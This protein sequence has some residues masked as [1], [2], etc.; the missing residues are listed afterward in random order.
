MQ[1]RRFTGA[2]SPAFVSLYHSQAATLW[3]ARVLGVKGSALHDV[4]QR[5]ARH[6]APATPAI[7]PTPGCA[8]KQGSPT[9][10]A[11]TTSLSSRIRSRVVEATEEIACTLE[12]LAALSRNEAH[13]LRDHRL[14]FGYVRMFPQITLC[15]EFDRLL[16]VRR[17]V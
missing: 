15:P 9:T 13:G 2:G 14:Q 8:R 7:P 6:H 4:P 5:C 10:G 3:R 11:M 16:N 1:S 17:I 12:N